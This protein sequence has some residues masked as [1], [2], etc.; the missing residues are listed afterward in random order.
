MKIE[1]WVSIGGMVYRAACTNDAGLA[2]LVTA[3]HVAWKTI[4]GARV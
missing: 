4:D 1:Y 3:G 2:A